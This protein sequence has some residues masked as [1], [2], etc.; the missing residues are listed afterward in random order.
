MTVYFQENKWK[1]SHYEWLYQGKWEVLLYSVCKFYCSDVIGWVLLEIVQVGMFSF[2]VICIC[3]NTVKQWCVDENS[4]VEMLGVWTLCFS[5]CIVAQTSLVIQ[6]VSVILCGVIL[7]MVFLHKNE[8]LTMY[9]GWVL[10]SS[11]QDFWWQ[12]V[13]VSVSDKRGKLSEA[14]ECLFANKPC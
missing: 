11:Q 9:H 4:S 1:C 6:N 3:I 10:V 14:R 2:L 5:L 8:L 7:M 12:K 13:N